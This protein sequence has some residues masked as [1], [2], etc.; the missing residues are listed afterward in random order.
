MNIDYMAVVFPG[1]SDVNLQ[2]N[3]AIDKALK[4]GAEFTSEKRTAA[5][6]KALTRRTDRDDGRF[7]WEQYRQLA[8]A[9][10]TMIYQAM[11]DEMDEGTQIF[12]VSDNPRRPRHAEL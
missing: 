9:G 3:I 5:Q 1:F 8:D 2:I 7:L 11:F 4:A 10:C 12:K 6:T